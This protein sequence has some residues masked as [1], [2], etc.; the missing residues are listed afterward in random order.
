M[1]Q[2]AER[3]AQSAWRRAHSE[4]VGLSINGNDILPR[5]GIG[6]FAF[7]ASGPEAGKAKNIMY[8]L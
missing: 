3:M 5:T 8:I 6:L 1:A 4:T 7:Q 2:S